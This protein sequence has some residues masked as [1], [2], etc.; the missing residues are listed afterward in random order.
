MKIFLTIC[1]ILF[2]AGALAAGSYL[3]MIH[4]SN[5]N[6]FS[7]G[8]K[9]HYI[10]HVPATLDLSKPNALV[11]SLHGFGDW[12]AHQ[13]YMSGW[14][15]LADEE[16]FIVVY[17]MGT[18]VPLRWQLYDYQQPANNPSADIRFIADLIDHFS[19]RYHID[20][21][22]IYINGLSNGGG[23]AQAVGCALSERIAAVGGVAGAYLYPFSKC[24]SG[25]AMPTIF[26]HGTADPVVPYEGG[27]SERFDIPFPSIPDLVQRV[28]TMNGCAE[29]AQIVYEGATVQGIRYG[30]CT[31]N[32]DVI[33]Y[34]IRDGGHSWPGGRA[35]PHWVVG[36]T[37]QEINATRL[38]WGF[39]QSHPL[40]DDKESS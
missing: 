19:Q 1:V 39:F 4:R 38:M 32:A 15:D 20:P 11:I 31:N 14:N 12:P 37:N 6:L 28:A 5:G 36:E 18:K 26:F 35:M 9:R 27:P 17:P 33:F 34:T 30:N 23:M 16:G 40:P 3:L 13:M 21:A 24:T 10:L 7:G 2:S 22:R 8:V 25:R 29:Q